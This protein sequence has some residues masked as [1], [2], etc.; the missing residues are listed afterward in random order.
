MRGS[1]ASKV[2][3]VRK[4]DDAIPDYRPKGFADDPQ[5]VRV[6]TTQLSPLLQAFKAWRLRHQVP[7]MWFGGN[8][9]SETSVPV[10]IQGFEPLWS[11]ASRA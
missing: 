3:Y 2:A 11:N 10:H 8:T 1:T 6:V 7:G 5:E 9:A 4:D